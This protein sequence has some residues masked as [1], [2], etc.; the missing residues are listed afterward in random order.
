M[1]ITER[2][3]AY[4][5]ER[6]PRSSRGVHEA[7]S[8]EPV[9]FVEAS[10]R[11]LTWAE[12]ARGEDAVAACA[13]AFARFSS[14]VNLAQARYEAAGEYP[15]KT[16]AECEAELY[17][18]E[19]MAD[20]LWGVYL[21]NFLWS[22]HFDLLT[23]FEDRFVAALPDQ[24]KLLELAPGHGGWGLT[25][26]H[27]RPGSSLVGY[28]IAPSSIEIATRLANAA[29]VE[30]RVDYH[31]ADATTLEP[32][33]SVSYDAAICCFLLEHLEQP[34]RVVE[35]LAAHL[36]ER[37][38][39]FVTGALTAAQIDHIYE[40]RDESEL[41]LLAEKAGFRVVETRSLAPQR[42]LPRAKFLPRSM[43]LIVERKRESAP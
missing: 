33:P 4:L 30:D 16:H 29:D 2:L 5:A 22:H 14:D 17:G 21:T 43:G 41:C 11:L 7:R 40:F 24:A 1:S 8:I 15:N 34:H 27:R 35:V 12:R 37:G 18:Q 25:A 19:A 39:A 42:T 26:L 13:D 31:R 32:E 3:F 10:D 28:D 36:P 23:W 9:R 38:R 6:H 20:Y